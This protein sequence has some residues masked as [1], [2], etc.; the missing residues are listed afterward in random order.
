MA[1]KDAGLGTN[2][3][4]KRGRPRRTWRENIQLEMEW[5]NLQYGDWEN[6]KEWRA[7]CGKRRQL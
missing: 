6:R 3:R 7:G 2:M 1:E 5:R 4:R